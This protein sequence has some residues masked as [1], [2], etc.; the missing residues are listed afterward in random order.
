MHHSQYLPYLGDGEKMNTYPSIAPSS[1][2]FKG[3]TNRFLD[4]G[5]AIKLFFLQGV[6]T[7]LWL[8]EIWRNVVSA[9]F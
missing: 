6:M 3:A 1:F 5:F 9:A 2:D 7:I 8:L 4:D